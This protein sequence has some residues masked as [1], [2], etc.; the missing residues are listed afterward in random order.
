MM[1]RPIQPQ[2]V[3]G[4]GNAGGIMSTSLIVLIPVV[5]LGIVG[6][7]CFVGCVLQTGGLPGTPFTKYSDLTVLSNVS[8]LIAYWP[9]NDQLTD[10]SNPAPAVE[11]QSS[12]PSSYVD[13][14]TTPAIYPW[15]PFDNLPNP[16]GLP[17]NSAGAG[18]GTIAFNQ[19]GLVK[20]DTVQPGNDPTIITSCVV[21]NGAYVEVPFVPKLLADTAFTIEAWVRVGWSDGDPDA[22]RFVVDARDFPGKGFAIFAKTEDNQPH[23]Y[24]W[25]GV[26]GNG[27]AGL[28]GFTVVTTSEMTIT[29]SSGG[30]PPDPVYL[31]LT[32]DGQTLRLYV[33]GE[34]QGQGP[35]PSAYVANTVQPLWIGAGAPY[36]DRRPMQAA[37]MPGSPL[38]PFVGA[39]QDVALYRTALPASDISTHFR[40]GSGNA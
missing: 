18:F 7:L 21:V 29:L 20:G 16:P 27:G 1:D 38:F 37:G 33:N 14:T 8:N 26:A 5:L 30:S 39:I 9:L 12:I 4:I 40:N 13:M 22:L 32:C 35:L 17:V 31:A 25:A 2:R 3:I 15:P 23:V 34:Q 36:V 28:E 10:Q 24:R 6:M 19:P 11:R